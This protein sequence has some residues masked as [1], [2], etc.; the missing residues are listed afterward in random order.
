MKHTYR[1]PPG[2]PRKTKFVP[3]NYSMLKKPG[4]PYSIVEP[5]KH[6]TNMARIRVFRHNSR[7]FRLGGDLGKTRDK[8]IFLARSRIEPDADP[9]YGDQV[10]NSLE[11]D[12][13][14]SQV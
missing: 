8:P 4:S 1:E 12:L 7:E 6:R 9:R 14:F 11:L 2:L 10:R 5:P 3:V 13:Q